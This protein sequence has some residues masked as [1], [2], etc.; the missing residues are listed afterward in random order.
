VALAVVE[1]N[2]LLVLL[3]L[4]HKVVLAVLV[5]QHLLVVAVEAVALVL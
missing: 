1:L 2:L 3:E 5:A 4:P